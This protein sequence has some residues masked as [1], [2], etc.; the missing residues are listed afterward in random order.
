MLNAGSEN[1]R[2]G[3]HQRVGPGAVGHIKAAS[4]RLNLPW[5]DKGMGSDKEKELLG[6][7]AKL[8]NRKLAGTGAAA[9]VN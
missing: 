2:K 9:P 3:E 6:P 5:R 1:L 8:A 7:A 4:K